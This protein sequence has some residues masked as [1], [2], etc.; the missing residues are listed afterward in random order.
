MRAFFAIN[1]STGRL[2]VGGVLPE[3]TIRDVRHHRL[4][5]VDAPYQDSVQ[6]RRGYRLTGRLVILRTSLVPAPMHR[7][8]SS[9]LVRVWTTLHK[10][11]ITATPYGDTGARYLR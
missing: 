6:Y 3:A 9:V 5:L 7:Y 10:I 8:S 11:E 2:F 1:Q 4:R